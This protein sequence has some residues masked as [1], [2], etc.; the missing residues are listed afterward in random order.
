MPEK[1]RSAVFTST[2]CSAVLERSVFPL[3]GKFFLLTTQNLREKLRQHER[4]HEMMHNVQAE[5]AFL[6][7]YSYFPNVFI[8]CKQAHLLNNA[9]RMTKLFGFGTQNCPELMASR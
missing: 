2:C 6:F 9:T 1:C 8:L 3:F 4:Q 7:R 5:A